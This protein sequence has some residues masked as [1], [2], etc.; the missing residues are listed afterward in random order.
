MLF[1]HTLHTRPQNLTRGVR[2]SSRGIRRNVV[3]AK[4]NSSSTKKVS[5]FLKFVFIIVASISFRVR[6]RRSRAWQFQDLLLKCSSNKDCK[7][8]RF[9][10][11]RRGKCCSPHG[12]ACFTDYDCCTKGHI[13]GGKYAKYC[14]NPTPARG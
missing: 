10:N 9:C 7:F 4:Y 5:S 13:C 2:Q 3:L 8:T 14:K 11:S 1:K 12:Y 6:T